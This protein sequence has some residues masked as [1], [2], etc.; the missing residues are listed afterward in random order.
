MFRKRT[1]DYRSEAKTK[2][3]NFAAKYVLEVL[4]AE[5]Q[6]PRKREQIAWMAASKAEP[7]LSNGTTPDI[8]RD[9]PDRMANYVTQQWPKIRR[10]LR[11]EYAVII[12]HGGLGGVRRGTP[13]DVAHDQQLSGK[14]LRTLERNFDEQATLANLEP[15]DRVRKQLPKGEARGR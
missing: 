3:L 9:D 12:V 8:F 2:R 5:D 10:L 15:W 14:T 1:K 13:D 11:T 7:K 6:K 4:P